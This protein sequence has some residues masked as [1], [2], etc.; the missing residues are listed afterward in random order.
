LVKPFQR[1]RLLQVSI[2]K[3]SNLFGEE[4]MI[5]GPSR[6]AFAGFGIARDVA[7][8]NAGSQ[9]PLYRQPRPLTPEFVLRST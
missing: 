5:S 7:S 8:K 6:P 1:P 3:F 4:P 2:S 9:Q